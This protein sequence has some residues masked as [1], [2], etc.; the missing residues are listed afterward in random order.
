MFSMLWLLEL[1]SPIRH[2]RHTDSG[3]DIV[4]HYLTRN[5]V[6]D[7]SPVLYL[8]G[9]LPLILYVEKLKFR[10]KVHNL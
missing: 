4:Q 3:V 2:A 8:H 10:S 7:Y 1:T 6:E 9:K 5:F